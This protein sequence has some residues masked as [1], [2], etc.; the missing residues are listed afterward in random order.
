MKSARNAE[1]KTVQ[2]SVPGVLNELPNPF[3]FL[4]WCLSILSLTF[5]DLYWNI[6]TGLRPWPIFKVT[7]RRVWKNEDSFDCLPILNVRRLSICTSC[8]VSDLYMSSL[9]KSGLL[10][11][12]EI[13]YTS[14]SVLTVMDALCISYNWK[15]VLLGYMWLGQYSTLHCLH[16]RWMGIAGQDNTFVVVQQS[17]ILPCLSPVGLWWQSWVDDDNLMFYFHFQIGHPMSTT[18]ATKTKFTTT[19]SFPPMMKWATANL[20]W[21]GTTGRGKPHVSKHG[22]PP[23]PHGCVTVTCMHWHTH[24]HTYMHTCMDTHTCMHTHT[25]V[26]TYTCT[27][28]HTH[29]CTHTCTRTHTCSHAHIHAH[30][31]MHTCMHRHMCMHTHTHDIWV[32]EKEKLCPDSGRGGG[33]GRDHYTDS[34][35]IIIDLLSYSN[36]PQEWL[37]MS[38]WVRE[39]EK[40]TDNQCPCTN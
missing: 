1:W 35:S 26:N 20:W 16:A 39:R 31:Y 36:V 5:W 11:V 25:H 12:L 3:C 15:S 37:Y 19:T 2:G 8:F 27:H 4:T 10:C 7:Q 6:H 18:T 21:T 17:S 23:P 13:N 22:Q 28:T 40:E 14:L 29:T 32:R 9:S 34:K 33:G 38:E 24:M 30:T